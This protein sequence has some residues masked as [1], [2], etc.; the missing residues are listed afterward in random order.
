MVER[1]RLVCSH[2]G[3]RRQDRQKDPYTVPSKGKMGLEEPAPWEEH[4]SMQGGDLAPMCHS[5]EGRE[6]RGDDRNPSDANIKKGSEKLEN[7]QNG[8]SCA[9]KLEGRLHE[10]LEV[11]QHYIGPTK[12]LIRN[13]QFSGF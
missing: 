6:E 7:N 1:M 2:V 12:L 3:N 5:L 8:S 9:S 13:L 10:I 4:Y 11:G